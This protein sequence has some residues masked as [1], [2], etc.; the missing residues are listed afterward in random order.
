MYYKNDL[1]P[2]CIKPA[3]EGKLFINCFSFPLAAMMA[4]CVNQVHITALTAEE[5]IHNHLLHMNT[6]TLASL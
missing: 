5:V 2:P 3:G 4:L 6:E 1:S